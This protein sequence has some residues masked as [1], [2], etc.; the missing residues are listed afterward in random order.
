MN[1]EQPAPNRSTG[2]KTP[3]GKR[4]CRLNAYRHGLTGQHLRPDSR[5]A[6]GL[7]QLTPKS[8]SKPW[9]PPPTSSASSRNRSPTTSGVSIA[10][11]PSSPPCSPSACRPA[12]TTPATPR[13]TTLSPKS[14][15]GS[16]RPTISNL[17]TIYEQRIQRKVDK[18][19]AQLKAIQTERKEQA[20][21]AMRQA[22]LLYQLAEAEGRPYQP[23]AYFNTAPEVRESVFSTHGNRPRAEPRKTPRRRQNLRLDR[24]TSQERGGAGSLCV[25]AG[26][27]RGR[28]DQR[29]RGPFSSFED[30]ACHRARLAPKSILA[31]P[32]TENW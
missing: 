30:C 32:Y 1:T 14:A 28:I 27:S 24:K 2:P 20:Q 21:E 7:R 29:S 6:A 18:N 31:E 23:E 13:S 9:P 22:K 15:P 12:S 25:L 3:E 5:R 11:K 26:A 19:T 17:L 8:S 10:P 16:R 4:V